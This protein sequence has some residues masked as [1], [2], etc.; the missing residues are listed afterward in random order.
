MVFFLSG[1]RA[2]EGGLPPPFK[3]F[4]RNRKKCGARRGF[5]LYY[6]C[7]VSCKFDEGVPESYGK[8][9]RRRGDRRDGTLLRDLDSLH[10]ITGI[11]YPNRCDNEA[12]ISETVDLTAINAYLEKK[13]QGE[14]FRY[15]CSR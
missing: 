3:I 14:D 10:F 8:D 2:G 6:G 11:I 9:K 7:V 12:Y 15:T 5:L 4:L 13:N 1:R